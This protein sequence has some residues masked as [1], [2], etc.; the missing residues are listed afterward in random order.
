LE[1][2]GINRYTEEGKMK[3]K[4]LLEGVGVKKK[5]FDQIRA[6]RCLMKDWEKAE[7]DIIE[8]ENR[9][10]DEIY[11]LNVRI[12]E[13]GLQFEMMKA[14]NEYQQSGIVLTFNERYKQLAK[15]I[16]SQSNIIVV[17]RSE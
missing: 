9:R 10:L 11:P 15:A 1:S 17:E 5:S 2:R 16:C 3:L 12:D 4:E 7:S 13:K 8:G 6:S 14:E